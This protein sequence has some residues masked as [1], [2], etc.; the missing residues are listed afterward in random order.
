MLLLLLLLQ[1]LL[2]VHGIH[3][4]LVCEERGKCSGFSALPNSLAKQIV[5]ETSASNFLGYLWQARHNERQLPLQ[6]KHRKSLKI[7]TDNT[8]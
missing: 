5:P 7:S 6:N 1:P 3:G 2:L 4:L 8:P